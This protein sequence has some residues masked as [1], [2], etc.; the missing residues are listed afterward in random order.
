VNFGN[1]DEPS[2]PDLYFDLKTINYNLQ[3]QMAPNRGWKTTIGANGMYQQ[4]RNLAAEKIIPEYS[5]FDAGLLCIQTKV[6]ITSP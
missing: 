3:Y 2:A 6:S 5:L 4:N 1:P